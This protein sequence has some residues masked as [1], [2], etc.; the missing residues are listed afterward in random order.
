MYRGDDL[1][2]KQLKMNK[3]VRTE[4]NINNDDYISR[5]FVDNKSNTHYSIT[6]R[7]I[8][9][10]L[11]PYDIIKLT[12]SLKEITHNIHIKKTHL[13]S[14]EI[15]K[16]IKMIG[17]SLAKK[18]KEIYKKLPNIHSKKRKNHYTREFYEL[19]GDDVL[20]T[21]R[22]RLNIDYDSIREFL[23]N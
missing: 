3:K 11:V 4:Y 12:K 1:S 6:K 8:H 23:Y 19:Y 18:Y 13:L 7:L 21:Y 22:V 17:K 16:L 10:K 9:L 2:N 20:N 15:N 5:V 14:K